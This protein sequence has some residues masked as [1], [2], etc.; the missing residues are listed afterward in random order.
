MMAANLVLLAKREIQ[1]PEVFGKFYISPYRG[2]YYILRCDDHD[3]ITFGTKIA[4]ITHY[5]CR[6]NQSLA[7]GSDEVLYRNLGLLVLGCT[8]SSVDESNEE[9]R[10]KNRD[11]KRL[12]TLVPLTDRSITFNAVFQDG[13]PQHHILEY[14]LNGSNFYILQ[15]SQ[16]GLYFNEDPLTNAALHLSLIHGSSERG[17]RASLRTFGFL[18]SDCTQAL[19]ANNNQCLLRIERTV[20]G[21]LPIQYQPVSVEK[22]AS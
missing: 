20:N 22:R 7:K 9:F 6:H 4:A 21:E 8:E 19:A 16:H 15:C 10:K 3:N 11:I 5:Q 2:K 14:P 1:L 17:H 12:E 13:K 18:V